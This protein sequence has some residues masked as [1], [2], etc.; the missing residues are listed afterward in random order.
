MTLNWDSEKRTYKDAQT[1]MKNINFDIDKQFHASFLTLLNFF[2]VFVYYFVSFWIL[3]DGK[4][5]VQ[6]KIFYLNLILYFYIYQ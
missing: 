6:R 5:Q 4:T 2:S 1:I 3:M